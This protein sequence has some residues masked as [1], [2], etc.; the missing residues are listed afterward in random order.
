MAEKRTDPRV[1]AVQRALERSGI[2]RLSINGVRVYPP[3]TVEESHGVKVFT[4]ED[5][6]DA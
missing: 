2:T 4:F 1:D 6:A 5:D 3:E